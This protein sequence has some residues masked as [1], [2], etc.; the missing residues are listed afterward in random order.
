VCATLPESGTVSPSINVPEEV[1]DS[2]TRQPGLGLTPS[3]RVPQFA[4]TRGVARHLQGTG[5]SPRG[6]DRLTT[7]FGRS[8]MM[9]NA[10]GTKSRSRA[11]RRAAGRPLRPA[12]RA[13]RGSGGH[14][15]ARQVPSRQISCL[16]T[17]DRSRGATN[18]RDYGTTPHLPAS[19]R[20]SLVRPRRCMG[21]GVSGDPARSRVPRR[22]P[23][24]W[25]VQVGQSDAESTSAG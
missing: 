7:A 14:G 22:A 19:G 25:P 12:T 13:A 24:A 23:L 18:P 3:V 9:V 16:L 8:A 11:S 2:G 15:A 10:R 1:A 17:P 5:V 20:T 6:R 4:G 21:Q